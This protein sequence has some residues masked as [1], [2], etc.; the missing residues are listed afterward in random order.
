M[1]IRSTDE[2]RR[3]S[4]RKTE[5]EMNRLIAINVTQRDLMRKIDYEYKIIF[6]FYF[7]LAS[8]LSMI[9]SQG[10]KFTYHRSLILDSSHGKS[11]SRQELIEGYPL[12]LFCGEIS[13]SEY[14]LYQPYLGL[15]N[16]VL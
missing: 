9:L 6:S 1:K 15:C 3:K 4:I 16:L 5:I 10:S 2:E 13:Q 7:T 8:P 11:L 12:T 14:Y